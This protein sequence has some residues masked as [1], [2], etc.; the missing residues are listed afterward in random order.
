MFTIDRFKAFA[1]WP[2]DG[3]QA[4]GL[5]VLTRIND[6]DQT[7]IPLP[8]ATEYLSLPSYIFVSPN[9][10]E[11]N[12]SQS[13]IEIPVIARDKGFSY[14]LPARSLWKNTKGLMISNPAPF[15]GGSDDAEVSDIGDYLIRRNMA[16]HV[17]KNHIDISKD[18][19]KDMLGFDKTEEL[20]QV[21][22][23]ETAVFT[24]TLFLLKNRHI[25]KR[26]VS[27]NLADSFFSDNTS[28]AYLSLLEKHVYKRVVS[29]ISP[30]RRIYKF[31]PPYTQ[32]EATA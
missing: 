26:E 4:V 20:P 14:N 21:T 12:E 30:Y 28:N 17:T 10:N 18:I 13:M 2:T 6:E 15:T 11:I 27:F 9:D 25:E 31:V 23:I 22:R 8:Q 7:V 1:G 29:L 16:D 19:V 3:K 24:L 32:Q 5:I